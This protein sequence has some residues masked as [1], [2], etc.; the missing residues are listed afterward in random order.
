MTRDEQCKLLEDNGWKII[1]KDPFEIEKLYKRVA[2][3]EKD[4]TE[5]KKEVAT[6]AKKTVV[7]GR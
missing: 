6:K 3:L 2:K 5:L 7:Y 4:M 1:S